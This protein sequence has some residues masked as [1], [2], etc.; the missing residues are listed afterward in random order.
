MNHK[1]NDNKKNKQDKAKADPMHQN[2]TYQ[3]RP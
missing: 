2:A 3:A 1:K